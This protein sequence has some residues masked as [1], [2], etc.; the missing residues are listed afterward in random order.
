M[1]IATE[2]ATPTLPPPAPAVVSAEN[3]CTEPMSASTVTPTAFT[4]AVPV[5]IAWLTTR[6]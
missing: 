2:P 1:L 5:M 6:T 3:S 4:D